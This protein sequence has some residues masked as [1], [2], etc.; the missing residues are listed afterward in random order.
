M[1]WETGSE[2]RQIEERNREREGEGEQKGGRKEGAE[3]ADHSL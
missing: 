1:H 3:G 2:E